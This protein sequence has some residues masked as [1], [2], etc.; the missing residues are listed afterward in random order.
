MSIDPKRPD[1]G[2]LIVDATNLTGVVVDVPSEKLIG[3]RTSQPGCDEVVIEVRSNQPVLGVLA[4]IRDEDIADIEKTTGQMAEIRSLLPA[5]RK[6]VE[7]LEETYAV[8]DDRLQR[9][10]FT[11]GNTVERRAKMLRDSSLL[12]RYSRTRAYRSASGLKAARTRQR[13]LA[14]NQPAPPPSLDTP[15]ENPVS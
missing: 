11:I 3:L 1:V 9:Q 2:D 15:D 6:L 10:L 13:N 7:L 12:A 8:L 4:G 14:E 5:S